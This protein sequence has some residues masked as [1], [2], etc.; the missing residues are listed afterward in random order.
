MVG[1]RFQE[2][3]AKTAKGRE[4]E[5]GFS[6]FAPSAHQ[7]KRLPLQLTASML[8]AYPAMEVSLSGPGHITIFVHGLH[9]LS[10]VAIP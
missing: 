5:W 3:T 10:T 6:S 2:R 4:K 8:G 9:G 7:Q 1:S